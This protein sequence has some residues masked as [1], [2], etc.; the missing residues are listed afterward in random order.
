MIKNILKVLYKN[1]HIIRNKNIRHKD[2][3]KNYLHQNGGNLENLTIEYKNNNYIFEKSQIDDENYILYSNDELEC[4]S[5]LINKLDKIAEIHG[6]GNYKTCVNTTLSNQSIGSLLLKITIKMLKKYKDT[7]DINKIVLVDNSVKRCNKINI[8]FSSM[9]ILLS[10]N[11]WY[12]KYGFRPID[13]LTYKL[14]KINNMKYNNN[15]SIMETITI[16]QANILKY[17]ELTNKKSIIDDIKRLID[18]YPNYLLIDF[19]KTFLNDYDKTCK[20]FNLFYKELFNDIG[21]TNFKGNVFGLD[22]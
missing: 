2:L 17:I 22:I 16:S 4:V 14:D 18:K 7:F 15:V 9:M 3:F 19:I 21:L 20:Y 11:T 6:I 12:G 8:E 10:G 13:N 1:S 5:I